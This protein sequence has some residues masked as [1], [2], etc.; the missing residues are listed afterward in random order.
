MLDTLIEYENK[1]AILGPFTSPSV[2][3]DYDIVPPTLSLTLTNIKNYKPS[4]PDFRN[5]RIGQL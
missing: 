1:Q 2:D 3:K 5:K 4:S